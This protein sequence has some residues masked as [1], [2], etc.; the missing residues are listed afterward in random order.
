VKLSHPPVMVIPTT[1][2]QPCNLCSTRDEVGP[3][4][5]HIGYVMGMHTVEVQ[6]DGSCIILAFTALTITVIR[7]NPDGRRE[8]IDEVRL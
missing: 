3:V 2:S 4:G 1:E 8:V 6:P 5:L 7:V